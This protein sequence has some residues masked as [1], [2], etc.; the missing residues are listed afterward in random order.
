[1]NRHCLLRLFF[2]SL[3]AALTGG[4]VTVADR[5]IT[6]C[7][8]QLYSYKVSGE[9]SSQNTIQLCLEKGSVLRQIYFPNIGTNSM[10]TICRSDGSLDDGVENELRIT[11]YLGSC[12]NGRTLQPSE[13]ACT[14]RK[15][16]MTCTDTADGFVYRFQTMALPSGR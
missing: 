10:P 3:L 16:K 9:N 2:A 8:G 14:K 1:M 4:C 6:D 13:W 15:Q 11:L 7:H 12:E 5:D